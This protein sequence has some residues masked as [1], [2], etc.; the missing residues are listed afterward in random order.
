MACLDPVV[1]KVLKGDRF[2]PG[3]APRSE[4]DVVT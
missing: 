3:C 2:C 1:R 4:I